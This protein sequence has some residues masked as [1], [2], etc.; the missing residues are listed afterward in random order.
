[1]EWSA[2]LPA[3]ARS[4]S[5]VAGVLTAATVWG[6]VW[7]PYRLLEQA[8]LSGALATSVTYGV[9]LVLGLVL[10]GH[11]L[12]GQH[13]TPGLIP[14]AIAAGGCNLGYVL[15]VLQGEV[16]RVL[17]L[18]YLSPLWTILLSRLLL[19]ERLSPKGAG[20]IG[21]SL[22]G[23]MIMLWHPEMG[24]PWP[25]NGSEWLGMGAGV[26][27][28]LQNVL[29]RRAAAQPLELK[30]LA[31][32]SGVILLGLGVL[33][34]EPPRAIPHL[35]GHLLLTLAAIGVVLLVANVVIQIA[36]G[37]L[38]ANR[39]SVM[40]LFELVVAAFSSWWLAGEIMHWREWL[41]GGLIVLA[42]AYSAVSEK[43]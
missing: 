22:L 24:L 26:F 20:V 23:A 13:F 7:Y 31:V 33:A 29:I 35:E 38:P 3:N 5:A 27:F 19:G 1:M 15:A 8:G 28:A 2:N 9:A 37:A 25:R 10:F 21:V 6:I 17:L 4:G 14:L 36:L 41:G 34:V 32:F 39:A 12:R 43:H 42:S 30:T 18:F 40:M 11:R 16:M